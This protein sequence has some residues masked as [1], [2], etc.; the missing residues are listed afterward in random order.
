MRY[1]LVPGLS[2]LVLAA[3]LAAMK[4]GGAFAQEAA[5]YV[6]IQSNF[7]MPV[8]TG[9][10]MHGAPEEEGE[11]AKLR[12]LDAQLDRQA[13]S[14]LKQ[15]SE[16]TGGKDRAKLKLSLEETL[17]QQFD[18]QQKVRELEVASIEARVKKLRDVI[19]KRNEARRTIIEKRLDQLLSEADGLGWNS[20]AGAAIGYG[21]AVRA[22]FF[23]SYPPAAALPRA[24]Q[25]APPSATPRA[26]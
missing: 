2:T 1:L 23:K 13:E 18:A 16:A 22:G 15:L 21:Q 6:P 5:E 4:A 7:R 3:G 19:N 20:P 8:V 26:Q 25:A 24:G 14:L 11:M 12:E 10:G 9:P 17:G